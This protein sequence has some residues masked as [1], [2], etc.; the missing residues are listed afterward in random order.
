MNYM[1]EYY[2]N[3]QKFNSEAETIDSSS[4]GAALVWMVSDKKDCISY[5]TDLYEYTARF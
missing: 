3:T 5:Y 4:V 2:T 1:A